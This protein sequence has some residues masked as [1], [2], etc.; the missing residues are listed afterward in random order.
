MALPPVKTACE[1]AYKAIGRKRS[2]PRFKGRTK[3]A[4]SAEFGWHHECTCN[5]PKQRD[6]CIFL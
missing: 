2:R 4:H 5:R 6:D 1:P 3:G